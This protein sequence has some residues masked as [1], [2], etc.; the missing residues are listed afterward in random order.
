MIERWLR[1][2]RLTHWRQPL[3]YSVGNIAAGAGASAFCGPTTP[4]LPPLGDDLFDELLAFSAEWRRLPDQ[5]I[6]RFRGASKFE[7]GLA[8]IKAHMD[9]RT[10][11]LLRDMALYFL[12]FRPRRGN[13]YI[14]LAAA[15]KG[16]LG[17][18]QL[19]TLN[20]DL[21]LEY[22]MMEVGIEGFG[23]GRSEP[24]RTGLLPVHSSPHLLPAIPSTALD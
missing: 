2:R 14:E 15:L 18:V 22:A 7:G 23:Y 12:R 9:E 21:L 10:M 11:E 4:R 20:Y 1:P 17:E 13:T 16:S 3:S 5:V 8:W 6:E 24:G 19:A